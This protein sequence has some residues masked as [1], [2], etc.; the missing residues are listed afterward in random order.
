[1]RRRALAKSSCSKKPRFSVSAK[2]Q[3][4]EVRWAN[5]WRD[6]HLA[7]DSF[8]N[9]GALE[10]LDGSV[11]SDYVGAAFVTFAKELGKELS[12]FRGVVEFGVG[13]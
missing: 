3:I 7:E 10:K 12:L 9:S 1:M 13:S 4:Y 11:T 5:F 6:T 2:V 8:S